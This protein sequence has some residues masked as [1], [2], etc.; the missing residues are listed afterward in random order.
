MCHEEEEGVKRGEEKGWRV[1]EERS[2]QRHP[3][4]VLYNVAII[5]PKSNRRPTARNTLAR[6]V[7]ELSSGG[8]FP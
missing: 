3:R 1:A 6:Y 8:G 2:R 5:K 7:P 4:S